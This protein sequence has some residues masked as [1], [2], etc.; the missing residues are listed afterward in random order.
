[1]S[2]ITAL[3]LGGVSITPSSGPVR[4]RYEPIGGSGVLRM[5]DGTGYKQTHWRKTRIISSG[6]GPL[7]PGLEQLDYSGPLELWCVKPLAVGGTALA[8]ELPPA[9]K[10]RPDVAPWAWAQIG[11]GW[12]ET[13]LSMLDDIA[14]VAAVPAAS[15]YR[16]SWLPR[17]EV[18]TDGVISDFDESSGRYDW[19]LDAGER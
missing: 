15:R 6:S 11:D 1:M 9:A 19:S 17:Y 12:V 13:P 4:Q 14:T 2:E 7:D 16:V 18:L 3:V 10:R 5:A 8:Y